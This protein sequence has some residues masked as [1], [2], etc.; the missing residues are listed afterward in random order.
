MNAF[1]RAVLIDGHNAW[2]RSIIRTEYVTALTAYSMMML[3]HSTVMLMPEQTTVGVTCKNVVQQN[4][5]S[6]KAGI[7]S[8][9]SQL[10]VVAGNCAQEC[11]PS[12]VL[13]QGPSL[14]QNMSAMQGIL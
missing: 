6:S 4:R 14:A 12:I 11:M 2:Y 1:S 5:R 8:L 10:T 13:L 7:N 3:K 9:C